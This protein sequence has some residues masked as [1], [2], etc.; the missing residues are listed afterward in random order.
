MHNK[1]IELMVLVYLILT[2]CIPST[3]GIYKNVSNTSDSIRPAEWDVSITPGNNS[4]LQVVPNS[5]NASYTLTVTNDS[6]VDV[7]YDIVISNL[8][9]GVE[10]KLDNEQNFRQQQSGNTI[11]IS[12]AGTIAYNG[13][14]VQHTL[15]FRAITGA[16]VVSNRTVNIDVV[17]KQTP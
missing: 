1:N 14:P 10:V 2:F 8:P 5:T 15:T 17:F 3:L 7:V 12:N 11:T 16:T 13:S 9:S 6:E 4:S